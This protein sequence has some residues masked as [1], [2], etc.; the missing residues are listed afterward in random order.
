MTN[1]TADFNKPHTTP[2]DCALTRHP[3]EQ[4]K[5]EKQPHQGNAAKSAESLKKTSTHA[6]QEQINKQTRASRLWKPGAETPTAQI[7]EPLEVTSPFASAGSLSEQPT[8]DSL[9][10]SGFGQSP[11]SLLYPPQAWKA[12]G[13]FPLQRRFVGF[14]SSHI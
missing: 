2:L 14:F 8:T 4:S 7:S 5:L 9:G 6:A 12:N 13:S 3:T 11:P 1:L 10:L